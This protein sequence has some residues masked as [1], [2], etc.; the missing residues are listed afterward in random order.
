[1]RK[2]RWKKSSLLSSGIALVSSLILLI[3]KIHAHSYSDITNFPV[4]INNFFSFSFHSPPSPKNECV[5]RLRF[6]YLHL[7]LSMRFPLP[8]ISCTFAQYQLDY[9]SFHLGFWYVFR[10]H[11]SLKFLLSFPCINIICTVG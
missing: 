2:P 8:L 5:L 4:V 6:S 11:F 9:S 1:V 3:T 7:I 10:R